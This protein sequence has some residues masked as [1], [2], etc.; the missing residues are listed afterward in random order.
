MTREEVLESIL[1]IV[2]NEG[3]EYGLLNWGITPAH[4]AQLT[5]KEI[6]TIFEFV[7]AATE[8]NKLLEK[9]EDE[10]EWETI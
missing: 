1:S 3:V 2:D 7:A 8:I 6:S 4:E 5:S 9:F 10:V